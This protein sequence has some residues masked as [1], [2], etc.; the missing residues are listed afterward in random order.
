MAVL[1]TIGP[2]MWFQAPNNGRDLHL[3]MFFIG[4]IAVAIALVAIVMVA[5]AVKALGAIR[6]VGESADELKEKVLPLL[7]EVMAISRTSRAILQETAPKV[8]IITDNLA[9]TSETLMDTSDLARSA[10]K[11]FDTT[12]A[13]VN[14]RAQKQVARADQMVTVALTTTAEVAETVANGI[15]VPAQKIA[16]MLIQAKVVAEGLLAKVKAMTANSPFGGRG[17]PSQP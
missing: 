15:R 17:G 13:D 6:G 8:K 9:K 11:R 10:V 1:Q 2:A 5:I 12:V 3:I 14:A 7:D 16:A 4:A